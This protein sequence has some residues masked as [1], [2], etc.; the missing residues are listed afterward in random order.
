MNKLL[1][2]VA[3][4]IGL[5]LLYGFIWAIAYPDLGRYCAEYNTVKSSNL[6]GHSAWDGDHY[7]TTFT[8]G[9]QATT[10]YV[11]IGDKVCVDQRTRFIP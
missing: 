2:I 6:T 10:N 8:D 11:Q 1:F 4:P 7:L 9:T 5:F 3:I